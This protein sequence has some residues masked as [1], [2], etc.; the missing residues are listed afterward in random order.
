M[1]HDPHS[2]LP[3]Y[4]IFMFLI[5]GAI[6]LFLLGVFWHEVIYKPHIATR[7]LAPVAPARTAITP[8]Y[9]STDSA[10]P[11]TNAEIIAADKQ[12]VEVAQPIPDDHPFIQELHRCKEGEYVTYRGDGSYKCLMPRLY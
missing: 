4:L 6:A 2:N 3:T 12:S 11:P 10:R 7:D 8:Y 5:C 9:P 1:N